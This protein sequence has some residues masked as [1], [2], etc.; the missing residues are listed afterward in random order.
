MRFVDRST[1]IVIRASGLGKKNLLILLGKV[2]LQKDHPL[3]DTKAPHGKVTIRH[4]A[5]DAGVS[6]AAVSKVLRNAY[7]VSD[8][9]RAKVLKSIDKLGYRPSTAARGMRGQTYS[10][11]MLLVEMQNPFLP[12][13]IEGAKATLQKAGYKTLIGVG[14][15]NASIERSLIDS[16]IDLQMDGLILV[17]PRISGRL[18]SRYT[19]QK[20][21]VVVGHHEPE[22][23]SFDTVNSD[24][25]AGAKLAVQELIAAGCH[26]IH[27]ISLPR[28]NEDREVFALRERGYL[29][30][31]AEAGLSDKAHIWRVRERPNGPGTPLEE[32]F[33][34]G[35]LPDGLFC[36]SDIHAIDVLNQAHQRGI[37]VPEQLA[38]VGYDN[39]PVSAMPMI[40]LSSVEQRGQTLGDLAAKALLS[41][42]GGRTKAEHVMVA[43]EL[44]K[45]HSLPH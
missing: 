33:E 11:G 31:M 20:P 29:E 45:R 1:Y 24:D 27:M 21:I 10:I 4:V 8:S 23:T 16:M 18:L 30:A 19:A 7:G 5:S 43:P 28:I 22:A 34:A 12:T 38:V 44:F 37:S 17:A 39:T 15:A 32:L 40:G 6:V 9:L 41:R 36:W 42:I 14:E 3:E 13:V 2:G 25:A 35:N 26:T